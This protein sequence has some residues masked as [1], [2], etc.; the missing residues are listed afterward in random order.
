VRTLASKSPSPEKKRTEDALAFICEPLNDQ[1]PQQPAKQGR[2]LVT[3]IHL[4]FQTVL[5]LDNSPDDGV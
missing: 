5:L 4:Q 2:L 3:K 1:N